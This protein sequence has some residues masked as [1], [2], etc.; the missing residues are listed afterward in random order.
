LEDEIREGEN[1]IQEQKE[2]EG[3]EKTENRRKEIEESLRI[4]NQKQEQR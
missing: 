3:K 4:L 2:L 1:R